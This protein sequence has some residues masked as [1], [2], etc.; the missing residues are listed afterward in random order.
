MLSRRFIQQPTV[1]SKVKV[2]FSPKNMLHLIKP[3]FFSGVGQQIHNT[4]QRKPFK[5]FHLRHPVV[6][7]NI[8]NELITVDTTVD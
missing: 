2:T 4:F 7:Y 5:I 8:T 3:L 1:F 6:F